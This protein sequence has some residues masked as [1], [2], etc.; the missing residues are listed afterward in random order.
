MCHP[1]ESLLLLL[2]ILCKEV[3]QPQS[4]CL[5]W[6]ATLHIVQGNDTGSRAYVPTGGHT[7]YCAREKYRPQSICLPQE[8][9]LHIVQGSGTGL[10]AYISHRRSHYFKEVVQPQSICLQWEATLHIV[11][12]NDTGPR[13]YVPT[14]GHTSYCARE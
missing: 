1:L 13:A 4:I 2:F 3:V 14:G 9:T 12:G 5:Q 6:E 7:S 8:V 11:Q 10:T